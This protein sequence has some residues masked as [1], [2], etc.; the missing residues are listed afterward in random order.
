MLLRQGDSD[1][2][3]TSSLVSDKHSLRGAN[4]RSPNYFAFIVNFI[5]LRAT[6]SNYS[7]GADSGPNEFLCTRGSLQH[8]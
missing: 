6:R 7:Y 8:H 4:Y 1:F 5:R 3:C 2:T